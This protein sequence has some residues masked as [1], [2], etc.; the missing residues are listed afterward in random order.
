[1]VSKK[2]TR[3]IT[4]LNTTFS[5]KISNLSPMIKND[6]LKEIKLKKVFTSLS[7]SCLLNI[8]HSIILHIIEKLM[9]EKHLILIQ[10]STKEKFYILI[11][12]DII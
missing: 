11:N 10:Y 4:N 3:K 5:K 9:F 1:M 12:P 7:I 2:S 8:K 6:I